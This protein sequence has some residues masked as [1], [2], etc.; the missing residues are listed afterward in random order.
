MPSEVGNIFKKTGRNQIG[1][2]SPGCGQPA[3]MFRQYFPFHFSC[4][5]LQKAAV[6]LALK[7]QRLRF[8]PRSEKVLSKNLIGPISILRANFSRSGITIPDRSGL[9]KRYQYRNKD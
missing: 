7:A 6:A 1:L 9:I 4:I 2:Q 8:L 3:W 5:R